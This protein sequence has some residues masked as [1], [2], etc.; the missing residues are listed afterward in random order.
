M[1]LDSSG[2]AL[3]VIHCFSDI[4]K[5]G[6]G[7]WLAED[8]IAGVV[9]Y[10][11][12]HPEGLDPPIPGDRVEHVKKS[13]KEFSQVVAEKGDVFL[14]HGLLPHCAGPNYLHFARIIS[15]PHVC[16]AQPHDFNR[17][18]G[19]YNLI[20]QVILRGLGRESVPEWKPTRE[21]AYWFPRNSGFKL[22][23]AEIELQR[24]VDAAKAKGLP[25]SSVNSLYQKQGTPEWDA[26]IKRNGYD[27]PIN[28]KG[29]LMEQHDI[30]AF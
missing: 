28:P 12:D 30:G 21:P 19:N 25:E 10:L 3:T 14:L 9:K 23:Y 8:G 13:C 11:Y 4:P 17:A 29:N 5:R 16:M 24:M 2:D 6:G 7:T 15:N 22:A 1:F 18:D 26:Y 27:L 20:E